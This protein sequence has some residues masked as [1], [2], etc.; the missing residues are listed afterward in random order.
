MRERDSLT[1]YELAEVLGA[2]FDPPAE[3]Q[4]AARASQGFLTWENCVTLQI[5]DLLEMEESGAIKDELR[6]FGVD[7]PRGARWYNFDPCT[8]L[9]CG[10]AGTFGG[11]QDGDETG[12]TYVPGPVAVMDASG[13]ITSVDPRE[14]DEPV[15]EIA[16][17]TWE[18]FV[19]FLE[20]GQQYE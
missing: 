7:A 15:V 11:W 12:R 1:L 2:S 19:E 13:K 3:A 10:V 4:A 5:Q 14:L 8:Y 6:Y 17:V 18:V 16:E 9:E 20:A